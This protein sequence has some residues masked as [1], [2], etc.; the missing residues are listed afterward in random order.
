MRFPFRTKPSELSKCVPNKQTMKKYLDQFRI[1]APLF[2]LF[3]KHVERV[4][5]L[6][7]ESDGSVREIFAVNIPDL[8]VE[9]RRQRTLIASYIKN[10]PKDNRNWLAQMPQPIRTEFVLHIMTR[11]LGDGA[12]SPPTLIDNQWLIL[13]T[14]A[15][16][17]MAQLALEGAEVSD[18]VHFY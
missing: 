14:L 17:E 11:Y 18:L 13:G 5:F 3:L 9:M 2:L 12:E 8:G 4:Q 15:N 16:G 10:Q 1:E 7:F 6:E